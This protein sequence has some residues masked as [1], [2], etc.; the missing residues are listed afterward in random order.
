MV[1]KTIE[2]GLF[3]I[4]HTLQLMLEAIALLCII[5]GLIKTIQLIIKLN[6][7][8]RRDKFTIIRLE[9][10]MWLVLALEFQLGADIVATTLNS[11]FASLVKLVIIAIVRTVLNYFLTKELD[12]DLEKSRQNESP[13][14][15]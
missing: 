2:Q 5:W 3:I 6:R 8:H 11:D 13:N 15:N 1:E 12:H 10:G 9:F 14:I 4:A 7:H